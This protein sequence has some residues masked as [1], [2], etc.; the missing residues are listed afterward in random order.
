MLAHLPAPKR[1]LPSTGINMSQTNKCAGPDKRMDNVL[2]HVW[3]LA[4]QHTGEP[5]HHAK[6]V[7]EMVRLQGMVGAKVA[8]ELME[9]LLLLLLL[10]NQRRELVCNS[11]R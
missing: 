1:L 9:S 7:A 6:L 10:L 2:H 5:C 8:L 4:L 3:V 11:I